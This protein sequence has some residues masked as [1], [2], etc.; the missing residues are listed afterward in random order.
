MIKRTMV[1]DLG[2]SKITKISTVMN[3]DE[4]DAIVSCVISDTTDDSAQMVGTI[5]K[6]GIGLIYLS[7]QV[8]IVSR[9]AA[10]VRNISLKDN[11]SVAA[12]FVDDPKKEFILIT[13]IQGMKRI[14]RETMPQGSRA[15]V[16]KPLISQIKS[17]PIEVLNAF[18]VNMNEMIHNVSHDGQWSLVK[19]SEI[20][21]GD[22][23]TRVSPVRGKHSLFATKLEPFDGE[24]S[25]DETLFD[26]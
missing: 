19:S 15:N 12:I 26:K 10:G 4:G 7:N 9:N 1:K 25:N 23:E 22:N 6:Y 3:L 8:S 13:C 2:I 21:I 20:V 18:E 24:V 5:T 16:G 14:R 11:D 17:N